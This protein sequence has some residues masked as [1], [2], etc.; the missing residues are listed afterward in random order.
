MKIER[1]KNASKNIV[2]GFLQR[3]QQTLLP[4]LMR[5]LM[6]RYMGEQYLGLSSLFTSVLHILNLAE[7]GVGSAM[8]FSMYKPI[9]EDDEATIC[10]LMRLYRTYYRIIGLVVGAAGLALTPVIPYLIKGTVPDGL[11]VY[12]LY[13]LNLGATVLTYWLFAYKN[14]LMQ[15]HQRM[16][17]ISKVAMIT[18][19][20][21][22][23]VQAGILIVL[24]NYYYYLI[25]ALITQIT[26]NIST[27]VVAGKMYPN[28]KP[29]G[30][31]SKETAKAINGRIRDLFTSKMGGVI[32]SSGDTVVISSFLGLSI[33]GIYQNYYFVLTAVVGFVEMMLQSVMAGLGNSLVTETNEKNCNDLKKFSFMFLWMIGVGCCCFLAMYQ[34]FMEI[35]V[36]KELMLGNGM[37]ICFAAYFFVLTAYR[38]MNVHKDAAGLWHEDR[39][40]P[41][42]TGICNV[43]LNLLW[44]KHWGVYGVLLSTVISMLAVGMPWLLHNMFTVLFKRKQMW[45]YLRLVLGFA[46]VTAI[47]G[48]V[49]W[50]LCRPI[51]GNLW[52]VLAVRGAIGAVVPNV[53]FFLLLHRTQQFIPAVQMVDKL[54]KNKLKLEQRFKRKKP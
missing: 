47:A 8:V 36:G 35:W 18:N 54:T 9:A 11:N 49:T 51:A 53:L 22:S 12:V 28:Y 1:T 50:W 17:I 42:V 4:F 3:V 14:C 2:F 7:L 23:A 26:T 16:D 6:I 43:L 19:L 20:L 44:I 21:Q 33:L 41:L 15:A 30:K 52:M 39:F 38:L 29:R 31:L 45:D 24:K 46:A 27:A 5:T 48:G 37:V 10:A 34:P 13:L 40:R 25:V 32:L